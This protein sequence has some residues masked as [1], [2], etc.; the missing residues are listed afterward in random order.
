MQILDSGGTLPHHTCERLGLQ[1]ELM[2]H[3]LTHEPPPF[4][5]ALSITFEKTYRAAQRTGL[6]QPSVELWIVTAAST[7]R[8]TWL[9]G[10]VD[11]EG[12]LGQVVCPEDVL[13]AEVADG[14]GHCQSQNALDV[15]MVLPL[16][17]QLEDFFQNQTFYQAF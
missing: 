10:G 13:E 12:V 15:W 8:G 17:R 2:R 1:S 3:T 14:G 9:A 4:L 7:W 16:D 11:G 5:P 6:V